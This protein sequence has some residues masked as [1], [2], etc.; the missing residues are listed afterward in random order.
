M[1]RRLLVWAFTLACVAGCRG[2]R[3]EGVE[4]VSIATSYSLRS[5]ILGQVRRINVY[6]PPSYPSGNQRYPVVYLLDGGVREDFVHIAGLASLAADFRNIRE[7]I[8]VGIEGIDRYHD[9]IYPTSIDSERTRL[10]TSGGSARFRAFL[11]GELLPYVTAHFRVTDETALMGESAAGMFVAETFLKEPGLFRDYVSV[12]PMLWWDNESL[13]RA[14]DSLLSR[15]FPPGRRL[16]LTIADEGGSMREGV[17]RLVAA[18]KA[19]PRPDLRWTFVPM[20]NETHGT[21]FHPAALMAVREL[22]AIDD[23]GK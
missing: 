6:L 14:A 5:S 9:L 1:T 7:F 2:A 19:Y 3:P 23:S 11:A 8:V 15:P 20:E 13:A 4:P 10:P 16:F 21:I 17:D 22:F 18:L 12:S